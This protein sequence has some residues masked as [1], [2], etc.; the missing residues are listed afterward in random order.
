MLGVML[1][2]DTAGLEAGDFQMGRSKVFIKNPESLS[3]LE[4]LRE[5]KFDGYCRIIQAACDRGV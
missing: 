4:D 1:L 2:L 5:R 3:L